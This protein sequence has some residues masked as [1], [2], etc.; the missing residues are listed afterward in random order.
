MF[1]SFSRRYCPY[2]ICTG[3]VL[4]NNGSCF[5]RFGRKSTLFCSFC[6]HR[7]FDPCGTCDNF[8]DCK[9]SFKKA[10]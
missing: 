5:C 1:D 2:R 9:E 8:R 4:D 7:I 6:D 3:L 10:R